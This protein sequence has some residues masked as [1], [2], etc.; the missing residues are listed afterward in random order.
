MKIFRFVWL[1]GFLLIS[2]LY[3]GLVAAQTQEPPGPL[4]PPMDSMLDRLAPPPTVDP[5]TQADQG[6]QLFYQ[7][8]MVCHGDQGQGLTDEWRGVLDPEDQDCWQSRCHATNHPVGGFVFP[9]YVPP[10]KG[11]IIHSRF[12][13]G[14]DLY[15]YI[16]TRMPWQAPGS[17]SDDEYWQLT[18]YLLR[19]SGVELGYSN[20]S[21][22]VAASIRL[23]PQAIPTQSPTPTPAPQIHTNPAIV[24]GGL[25]AGIILA[26]VLVFLLVKYMVDRDTR[27]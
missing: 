2:L 11:P 26:I 6:H 4:P 1:S 25:A 15:Q 5:P 7:I 17:R 23:D 22:E 24:L 19:L 9:K 16:K 18:A 14:L 13:T 21:P 27:D 20:L 8:C 3:F 10:V 12:S